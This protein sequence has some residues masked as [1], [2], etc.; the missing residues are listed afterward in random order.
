[1]VASLS[2]ANSKEGG[3]YVWGGEGGWI[4]ATASL[5]G[6]TSWLVHRLTGT[7]ALHHLLGLLLS[8]A[9]LGDR[10]K[11]PEERREEKTASV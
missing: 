10:L 3:V 5:R 6:A 7:G 1:M 4:K 11:Q 2:S 8:H 9:A